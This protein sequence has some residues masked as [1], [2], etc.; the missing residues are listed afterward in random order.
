MHNDNINWDLARLTKLFAL[1]TSNPALDSTYCVVDA[2]DECKFIY[3]STKSSLHKE[4]S[5]VF[6][7][8]NPE[9]RKP[10]LRLIVTSRPNIDI[11]SHL[12]NFPK[13]ELG[14]E[15]TENDTDFHIDELGKDEEFEAF[16]ICR[17]LELQK[18]VLS[19][20]KSGAQGMFL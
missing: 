4:I 7:L 16:Q 1:A 9:R 14:E 3:E 5:K 13:P 10:G 2:L 17:N 6:S 15:I 8:E 19:F 20:L 11:S 12:E 18:R